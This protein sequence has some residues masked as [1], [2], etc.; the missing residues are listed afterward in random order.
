MSDT[1]RAYSEEEVINIMFMHIKQLVKYWATVEGFNGKPKSVEDRLDGLA[2]SILVM[3]DGGSMVFP[4]AIIKVNGH[5]SD[6][7]FH[8]S[9]GENWFEIGMEIATQLHEHYAMLKNNGTV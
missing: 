1:P 6:K 5:P 3:L 9:Q 4:G 2:F 7:D 8:I